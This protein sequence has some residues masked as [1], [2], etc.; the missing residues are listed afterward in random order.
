MTEIVTALIRLARRTAESTIHRHR[1]STE[2]G[3]HSWNTGAHRDLTTPMDLT[4]TSRTFG[5]GVWLVGLGDLHDPGAVVDAVSVAL[6]LREGRGA[7]PETLLVEYLMTRK[8]LLVLDACEHLVE[9]V[10]ALAE[11]LLR[12]C[13]DLRIL[14][15][16]PGTARRWGRSHPSATPHDAEPQPSSGGRRRVRPL[17]GDESL[18]RT[19]NDGGLG[20]SQQRGKSGRH[21]NDLPTPRWSAAGDRTGGGAAVGDVGGAG[22]ATADPPLHPHDNGPP[23]GPGTAA[24]HAVVYRLEPRVVHR[25]RAETV[26]TA[27]CVRSQA[28]SNST[29]SKESAPRLWR[30]TR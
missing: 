19:R 7:P 25:S 13:P 6:E 9:P 20:M 3:G 22:P 4:D 5:D 8:L 23:G 15:T 27:D 10:A 16:S 2:C 24:N 12:V 1:H 11:T 14:A 28:A 21:R 17:R 18:R 29:P 26:G 30:R